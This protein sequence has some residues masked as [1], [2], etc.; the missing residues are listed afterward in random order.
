VDSL[1][2]QLGI[3]AEVSRE[4]ERLIDAHADVERSIRFPRLAAPTPV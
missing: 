3:A 4:V 2:T 1:T